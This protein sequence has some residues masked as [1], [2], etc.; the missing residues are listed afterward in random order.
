M[1]SF[2]P[3]RALLPVLAAGLLWLG[4][5]KA[6]AQLTFQF[7][8]LDAGVGFNDPTIG[9]LRR[10]SFESAVGLLG[11]SIQTAG[12]VTVTM[13]ISSFVAA[14]AFLATSDSPPV[15]STPGFHRTIM[16]EKI[17][18][19]GAVDGN[20]A[21]ADATV[22]WNFFHN[23]D[24]DDSVAAGAYDFKST[25]MHEV[26]HSLGFISQ[27]DG[28]GRGWNLAA[29][30]SPDAWSAFDQFVT[31]ASG[32]PLVNA[33]TFG[34]NTAELA[35]LTGNPGAYFAGPNAVAANGGN[36]VPLY[37]PAP[38]QGA[39]SLHHLDDASFSNPDA[40]MEAAVF[41][42]QAPRTLNGVELG[43]LQ[44]LGYTVVPEPGA[45]TL[46]LLSLAGLASRRWRSG[47]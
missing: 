23:W 27:I 25:V 40:L 19:L 26:M 2:A 21:T 22:F 13:G 3:I 35:A 30:G 29:V 28:A 45:V 8:Y 11:S 36:L 24:Y 43:I 4:P 1:M 41:T 39:S 46:M 7:N 12:P 38:F 14:N 18:T 10:S 37:S 20:G 32:V 44:D 31:T 33:G 15:S 6:Q 16:Q 34:F 47:G 42:G 9:T 5:V 17:L